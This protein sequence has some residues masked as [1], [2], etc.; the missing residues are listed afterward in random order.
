MCALY[1]YSGY[2]KPQEQEKFLVDHPQVAPPAYTIPHS[3]TTVQTA[4]QTQ[5][6]KQL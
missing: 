1:N 3:E 5:V 4:V 2:P 6:G